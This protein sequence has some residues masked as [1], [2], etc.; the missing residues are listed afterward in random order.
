MGYRYLWICFQ[1]FHETGIFD[2]KEI[3]PY[4]T[5]GIGEDII[6]K[7]VD[8]SLIDF[9]EKVNDRDAAIYTRKLALDEGILLG[10]SWGSN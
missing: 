7:N 9:F 1:K 2:K 5:E 3:Y 6:P 8:F 10:N 4:L